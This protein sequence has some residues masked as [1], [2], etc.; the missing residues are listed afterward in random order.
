MKDDHGAPCG[1]LYCCFLLWRGRATLTGS[2][3]NHVYSSCQL[4]CACAI[5][6]LA[7]THT[8][9]PLSQSAQLITRSDSRGGIY[10]APE[11]FTMNQTAGA[12]NAYR[13][14]SKGGK[15]RKS[16]SEKLGFEVKAQLRAAL[17]RSMAVIL[18]A[19]FGKAL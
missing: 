4:G 8:N 9:T 7:H 6:A 1:S 16:Y 18:G 11:V 19:S 14:C 2:F 17:E 5:A 10:D 15:V 3:L 13:R 12:T